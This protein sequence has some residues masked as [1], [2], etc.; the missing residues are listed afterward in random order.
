MSDSNGIILMV[1]GPI[2]IVSSA[3][4]I[5]MI[6]RSHAKL[7][8]CYHRLMFGMSI[9]DIILSS[10][11][12]FSSLPAPIGTPGEWKTLGTRST[13]NA[14]GFFI[15]FGM[16]AAPTYFLSLQIYYFC[17][18]KYQ[19]S[20]QTVRKN[21]EPYLHIAPILVGLIAAIVP[22]VTNSINPG[23]RGYCWAQDFPLH[24]TNQD[25]EC[26][27]G[28]TAATQRVLLLFLPFLAN[29]ITVGIMMWKIYAAVRE[30]DRKNASHNF[31]S[32]IRR[33]PRNNRA[34]E[35]NPPVAR[36]RTSL[37]MSEEELRNTQYEKSRKAR[38]RVLQYFIAYF[39]TYFSL[40]MDLILH[41]VEST[42][43]LCEI[44]I[45]IF[46]PLGG[47]FNLIVFVIPAV[48]KV[49]ERNAD[50]CLYQALVLSIVSYAGP[51][52]G[53]AQ[54]LRQGRRASIAARARALAN[55]SNIED[56][57][58]TDSHIDRNE[59]NQV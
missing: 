25:I 36:R 16:I 33:S 18:I 17:M 47:F 58:M 19:T 20:T 5:C 51:S 14:Q 34:Q 50:L 27:R 9:T 46:Y 7:S 55:S 2:S 21:V 48:H 43:N 4:I 52:N 10:G 38:K 28:E 11:L 12:S 8:I 56:R 45:M 15:M 57:V 23:S 22:L 1:T 40:V 30:Q 35:D 32:S 31:Q 29:V 39:L 59:S 53:E 54:T 37:I 42:D 26:I 41:N 44:L 24:C 3:M 13:C 49:R 6:L